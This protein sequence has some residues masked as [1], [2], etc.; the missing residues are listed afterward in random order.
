MNIHQFVQLAIEEDIKKGDHSALACIPSNVSGS[1]KLLVK[2]DGI[3]A[4]KDKA[5]EMG[6]KVSDG[7]KSFFRG[8]FD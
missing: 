6:S 1:A 2:E 7:V 4:G 5:V 3:I 8:I